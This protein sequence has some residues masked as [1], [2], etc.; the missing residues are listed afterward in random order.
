MFQALTSGQSLDFGAAS[1]TTHLATSTRTAWT[2]QTPPEQSSDPEKLHPNCILNHERSWNAMCIEPRSRVRFDEVPLW[3]ESRTILSCGWLRKAWR[4]GGF[5]L[6]PHPSLPLLQYR[7]TLCCII[8][9]DSPRAWMRSS[10]NVSAYC[11][12]MS[13]EGAL[14]WTLAWTSKVSGSRTW[15]G[16]WPYPR[17]CDFPVLL[18]SIYPPELAWVYDMGRSKP[19]AARMGRENNGKLLIQLSH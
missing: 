9:W 12:W 19:V 16:R 15:R 5:G 18:D 13:G 17:D 6:S 1:R 10:F 8:A 14:F 3:R 2:N 7:M 11:N 4:C